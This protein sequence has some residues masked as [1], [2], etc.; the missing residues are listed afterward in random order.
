MPPTR[1]ARASA[2]GPATKGS[3]KT[4]AFSNTKITK[5]TSVATSKSLTE[6]IKPSLGHIT[7]QAAVK[8]QAAAEVERIKKERTAEEA[9]AE[10]VT[11]AQVRKYWREREAERSAPRV[12]QEELSVEEKILR[13]FDISSQYGVGLT[14]LCILGLPRIQTLEA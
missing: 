1:R 6:P 13:L 4:L 11:D 14:F 9:K 3:Q 8:A 5:P 10:K 7:P 2:S 12:H